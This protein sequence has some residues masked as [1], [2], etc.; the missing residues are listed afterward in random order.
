MA[1][2]AQRHPR[3]IQPEVRRGTPPPARPGPLEFDARGFPIPQPFPSFARRVARML[4]EQS[5]D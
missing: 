2:Q 3:R 4:R 1:T 5:I